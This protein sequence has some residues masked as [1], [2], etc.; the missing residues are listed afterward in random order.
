MISLSRRIMVVT[1]VL[2]AACVGVSALGVWVATRWQLIAN[3][4]TNLIGHFTRL[5]HIIQAGKLRT[6][7]R[8]LPNDPRGSSGTMFWRVIDTQTGAEVL[9]SP[10]LDD[11]VGTLAR[12]GNANTLEPI[13]STGADE[14]DLRLM[15]VTL[16]RPQ[17]QLGTANPNDPEAVAVPATCTMIMAIDATPTE[18]ELSHFAILLTVLWVTACGLSLLGSVWLR[19]AILRPVHQLASAIR[20]IDLDLLP[21]S[22]HADVPIEM[23]VVRERLDDLLAR[24]AQVLAREKGT[25]ANI[26]HELRTPIAG[27]RT[28]LEFVELAGQPGAADVASR[29]LPTVLA[30]QGM[31]GNLL[32][33]ARIEAG[34]ETVAL[35]AVDLHDL[36]RD[37]WR[38]IEPIAAKRGTRLDL[39][40]LLGH[41]LVDTCPEKARMVIANLLDNAVSHSP[42]GATIVVE[43]ASHEHADLV[44]AAQV[45]LSIENPCSG[46]VFDPAALF[47]P[48]FRGDQARGSG[49][50]HCGLGLALCRRLVTL[51]GGSISADTSQ[52]GRFRIVVGLPRAASA[53]E[54]PSHE[55]AESAAG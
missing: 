47:E 32:T 38:S 16:V 34:Q 14:R 49:G 25:I 23:V 26:A 17:E 3:L 9:R 52:P 48:F 21:T 10:S 45:Q 44:P 6:P 27:L 19:R 31:V 28:T 22:V 39:G 33:L 35:E 4:D 13:W 50:L 43:I 36:V 7:P 20:A 18:R 2:I 24:L 40:R 12:E 54:L 53:A 37:C 5:M 42:A 8:N 11:A 46:P 15:S 55:P 41:P 30:M 29:C 1:V 51:L